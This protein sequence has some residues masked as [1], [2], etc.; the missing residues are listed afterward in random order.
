MDIFQITTLAMLDVYYIAYLM[1][2]FSLKRRGII[3]NLLGKGSK[4]QK[5]L[6][7]EWFLRLAT[8]GGAVIQFGSVIFS[9]MIWSAPLI[10]PVHIV[11]LALLFLGNIIFIMAMLTMRN[12]WRAGFDNNQNTN[13]VTTGIYKYSRN[14]AFVGF[15][16]LYIGCA[17]AFP[18]I[19]NI[20][21]ALTLVI[22]FHM[23]ILGEEEYCAKVF[24]Q[25]YSEYKMKVRRYF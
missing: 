9:D 18:N 8:L 11:G 20:I 19:I 23:Q 14:P 17:A 15:D 1:K 21:A 22:L 16:L 12:N 13:L 10:L 5:A 24:G 4:P 7:I 6:I 2:A 3:V 25:E